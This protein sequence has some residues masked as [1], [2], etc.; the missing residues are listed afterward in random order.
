MFLLIIVKF[1]YC[2]YCYYYWFYKQNIDK[3]Q[4]KMLNVSY[5]CI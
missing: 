1:Y 5:M 4:Y 3:I 2:Y